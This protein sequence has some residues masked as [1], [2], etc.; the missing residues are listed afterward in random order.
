MPRR[1]KDAQFC[2]GSYSPRQETILAGA[3]YVSVITPA[4]YE[5]VLKFAHGEV[6][7]S[8]GARG[9]GGSLVI[10]PRAAN[11]VHVGVRP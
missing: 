8:V 5:V 6:T 1:L 11:L 10:E 7:L 3:D 2:S 4:G 9:R